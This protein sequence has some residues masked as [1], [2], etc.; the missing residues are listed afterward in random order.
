MKNIAIESVLEVVKTTPRAGVFRFRRIHKGVEG[1]ADNFTLELVRLS[2]DF[3]SPR[4]RHNFDQFRFQLEGDFDFARN[5]KSTPGTVIYHPESAPYGPQ[6]S[7]EETLVLV[8]QFGGASGN[9]F[10]SAEQLAG[11]V[12]E[13]NKTGKFENGV[14]TRTH[15]NG[16]KV[17]TDGFEAAWEHVHGRAVDYAPPRYQDPVFMHRDNYDWIAVPDRPGVSVKLM[18]AFTE[19]KTEVGFV[20]LDAGATCTVTGPKIYF[21]VSGE[22]GAGGA[23]Y[24]KFTTL[25]VEAG[26]QGEISA[27]TA[28]EIYFMG[29]PDFGETVKQKAA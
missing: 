20:R 16:R 19:R 21:V 10:M 26:E 2:T 1:S 23:D 13:L 9:G 5:G 4:H 6:T 29:L 27:A 18:G 14:Y 11:A 8:L 3:Y 15:E 12:D 17:N 28:S 25:H 24:Q 7:G 22:G